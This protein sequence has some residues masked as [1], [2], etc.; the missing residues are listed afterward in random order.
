MAGDWRR[1]LGRAAPEDE[2]LLD[3]AVGPVLDVGCGPGRHLLALARRG[4]DGVGIDVTPSA[5]RLARSRGANV[6]EGS[7]F[8]PVP[9]AG[10]WATA[11]LLDGNIGIGG[12]PVTLLRRVGSLLAPHGRILTELGP[13]GTLGTAA[14]ARVEHDARPGPWFGWTAVGANAIDGIAHRA[15]LTLASSWSG[16][17]RWFAQ[18]A[19]DAGGAGAHDDGQSHDRG[20]CPD[21][22]QHTEEPLGVVA[23]QH[24]G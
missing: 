10:T 16:A 13:P 1:W 11:L 9:G 3:R 21:H 20:H 2:Q 5:V 4:V 17:G 19:L 7:I 8:G 24:A 18:I 14:P 15:G 22:A 12:D 23:R 6:V